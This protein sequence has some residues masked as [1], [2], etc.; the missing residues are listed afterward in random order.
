MGVPP[1]STSGI[2]PLRCHAH[3]AHGTHG[4]DGHVGNGRDAH[5]PRTM[6]LRPL[7]R[8]APPFPR[9]ASISRRPDTHD[10][11]GEASQDVHRTPGLSAIAAHVCV[12]VRPVIS[13]H[14]AVAMCDAHP[15]TPSTLILW[16]AHLR[17]R[18]TVAVATPAA[19]ALGVWRRWCR[20]TQLIDATSS[21]TAAR[22]PG[23]ATGRRRGR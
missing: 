3:P 21:A 12:C 6:L 15:A 18:R 9:L 16:A 11:I 7:R 2:L 1:T 10:N 14:I 5:T 19:V 23:P 4:R 8:L 17:T 20:P 22:G 13:P